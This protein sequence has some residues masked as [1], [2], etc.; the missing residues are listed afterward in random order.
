MWITLMYD[1]TCV[2]L[3]GNLVAVCVHGR[4]GGEGVTLIADSLILYL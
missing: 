2:L 3:R 4:G 1:D